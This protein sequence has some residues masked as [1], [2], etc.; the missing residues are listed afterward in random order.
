MPFTQRPSYALLPY[1][2]IWS[3]LSNIALSVGSIGEHKTTSI[4]QRGIDNLFQ[5]M[6]YLEL[7]MK[8]EV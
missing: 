1:V 4:V 6:V 8:Y 3:H 5:E 2:F 7:V